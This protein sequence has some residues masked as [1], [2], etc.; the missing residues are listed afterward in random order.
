MFIV[1]VDI[2][3]RSHEATVIDDNGSKIKKPFNFKNDS[4]GFHSLLSVLE[5]ISLDPDDFIIGMES[6]SHYW[7]ALYSGLRKKVTPFMC[8]T[9][10]NQMRFV[11]CTSDR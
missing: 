7:L 10:F 4:S 2:A 3:K 5:S 11:R 8:L 6:T 9:Q 1:G